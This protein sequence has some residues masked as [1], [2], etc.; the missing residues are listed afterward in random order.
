MSKPPVSMTPDYRHCPELLLKSAGWEEEGKV[1][2]QE[3]ERRLQY[4]QAHMNHHIH[5]VVNPATGERRPLRSCCKKGSPNVCK[6]DFPLIDHMTELPLLVCACVAQQRNLC[7]S[8]PRSLLGTIL[9]K[10]NDP[11]L[12]AGPSLWMYMT[13]DWRYKVSTSLSDFARNS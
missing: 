13:G 9:P 12:N 11:W 5:P 2:K 8:G 10:R 3:Y 1:W 6:G 7:H 4:V